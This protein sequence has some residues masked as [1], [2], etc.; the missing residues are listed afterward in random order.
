MY[1]CFAFEAGKT[2]GSRIRFKL[3]LHLGWFALSR[4]LLG[5]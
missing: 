1:A 5:H 3:K 4:L 2:N